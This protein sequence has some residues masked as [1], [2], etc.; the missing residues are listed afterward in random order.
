VFNWIALHR[1]LCRIVIHST[2]LAASVEQAA[3]LQ[4][5]GLCVFVVP[6]TFA[7]GGPYNL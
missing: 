5:L 2:N 6:F 4:G 3:R 1:P 7:P